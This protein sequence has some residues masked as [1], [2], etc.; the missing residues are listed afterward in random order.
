MKDYEFPEIIGVIDQN[1]QP[2]ANGVSKT[3]YTNDDSVPPS[4]RLELVVKDPDSVRE[5]ASRKD[6][7]DRDEYSLG[8]LRIGLLSLKHA[9]GQ[10]DAD[11]VK[12]EGDRIIQDL[13]AALENYKVVLNDSVTGVLKEYFDPTSGRFQERVERLIQKDGELEQLLRRQI[14]SEGSELVNTLTAHVG[15]NSPMMNILDPAQSDGVVQTIRTSAQE[16]L[17]SETKRILSE[18][19]LDN[20]DGAMSRMVSELTENNGKLAGDLTT[21]IQEV[22][23]EFSLDK[24]DSALSRLVR[25]VENAQRTIS[26]EFSLDNDASALARLRSELLGVLTQQNDQNAVFQRD[27]TVALEA[28]KAR[29]E[30]SLRSTIHGNDFEDVVVKFVTRESEKGGDVSTA[31]GNTVGAIKN[32]KV[33]D[34]VV[35]LGPDCIAH[36]IKF[37]IEAK[38]SRSYDLNKARNEIETAR[39]NRRASVG[40]F[41]FSKKMA[42]TGQEALLR[43]GNDIFV[44][45]DADDL[46]SDVVLKTALSL[47][48]ALC[49]R[50]TQSRDAEAAEFETIDKAI[51]AIEKEARRL[52]DMKKWTETIKSNSDKIL[53]SVRKMTEG[54]ESHVGIL[55]DAVSGLNNFAEISE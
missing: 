51:L 2:S 38:E 6:G 28:M 19:S 46:D 20:K 55:K 24:E 23:T 30:E 52:S 29:R 4:I 14:G 8:A 34:A 10:V 12:R 49:V 13:G 26:S 42:P 50:E 1:Q 17:E 22:V 7:R 36:G 47:A 35:E 11:A 16:I 39:R 32:C 5:V 45:W 44:V 54:L 53:E 9:R 43:I 18:F 41:V 48:K 27:V 15:E 3:S 33:G 37:V 21:K 31:T 25:K 40:L